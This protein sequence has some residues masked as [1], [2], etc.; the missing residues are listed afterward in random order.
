MNENSPRYIRSIIT[1][2]VVRPTTIAIIEYRMLLN[3]NVLDNFLR[4]VD[5]HQSSQIV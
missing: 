5:A 2:N 4:D 3:Q 1:K